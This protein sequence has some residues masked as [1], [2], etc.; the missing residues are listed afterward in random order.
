MVR[1]LPE[2]KYTA[3]EYWLKTQTWENVMNAETA[4][5]K[6]QLLQ[7]MSIKAM[8]KFFPKKEV[9]FTTDDEPW[10]NSKIKKEIRKRKRIYSK[11]RKSEAWTAQNNLV[12]NLVKN[13]KKSFLSKTN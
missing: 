9:S 1:P 10:I 6:A 13:A 3:F 7:D 4:H 11:H 5:E 12:K 2:S 8:D